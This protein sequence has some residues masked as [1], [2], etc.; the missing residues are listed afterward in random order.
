MM[1]HKILAIIK[2][3]DDQFLLLHNNPTDPRHGGDIWYTVTGSVEPEDKNLEEAVWREI[4][5][6]TNLDV[7]EIKNL[8][9]VFTYDDSEHE[10]NEEYAFL[11]T[12]KNG[13]ITLNNENIGYKWLSKEGFI[14]EIYWYYD[15]AKLIEKLG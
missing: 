5:E 4:K 13:E 6:E 10:N 3:Q 7:V 14:D 15:K 8:D 1:N 12:V 2:D 11:A 9:W